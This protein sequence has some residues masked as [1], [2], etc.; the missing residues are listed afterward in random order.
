MGG[1]R[2]EGGKEEKTGKR[3]KTRCKKRKKKGKKP[4]NHTSFEPTPGELTPR[5][6]DTKPPWQNYKTVGTFQFCGFIF[7]GEL[8]SIAPP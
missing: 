2:T 3:N 5:A 4:R 1:G 7:F 8:R 6:V